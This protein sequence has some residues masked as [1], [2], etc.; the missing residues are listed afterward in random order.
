MFSRRRNLR[1]E[2]KYH[3]GEPR[4]TVNGLLQLQK[5]SCQ[6]Q[7]TL[8][9]KYSVNAL[10]PSLQCDL[11]RSSCG[12]CER[13]RRAC[14]GYPDTWDILHRQQNEKISRKVQLKTKLQKHRRGYNEGA[15]TLNA[16]AIHAP[17]T[18]VSRNVD[19]DVEVYS[20]CQMYDDFCFNSGVGVLVAIPF[21]ASSMPATPFLPALKAAALAHSSVSLG[22]HAFLA[23]AKSAYCAAISTLQRRITE[24]PLVRSDSVLGSVFLLGLFEVSP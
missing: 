18:S 3:D 23:K 1:L 21:M 9:L 2:P 8:Y 10:T 22:Q 15:A 12:R 5:R 6:G 17:T 4:K 24:P 7:L 13:L 19:Y 14:P 11:Q 20:V 16:A